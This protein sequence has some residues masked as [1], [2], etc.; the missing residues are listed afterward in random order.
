MTAAGAIA[1]YTRAI[2]LGS[3]N[4]APYNNRGNARRRIRIVMANADYT[5]AIESQPDYA[6]ATT[7]VHVL[8][9]EKG[10]RL[11]LRGFQTRAKSSILNY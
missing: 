1:D 4:P 9:K 7:I 10:T 2:E 8:K 5:R 11:G 3:Q 6:R